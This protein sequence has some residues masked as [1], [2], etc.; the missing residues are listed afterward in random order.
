M[1]DA[2]CGMRALR[3]PHPALVKVAECGLRN[4]ARLPFSAS[5]STETRTKAAARLREVPT[6]AKVSNVLKSLREST[7]R[8]NVS[9]GHI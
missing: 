2:G 1:R 5:V 8:G 9:Y 7:Q 6:I 3:I 4:Q